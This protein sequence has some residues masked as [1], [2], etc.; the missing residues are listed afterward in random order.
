MRKYRIKYPRFFLFLTIFSSRFFLSLAFSS[1]CSPFLLNAIKKKFIPLTVKCRIHYVSISKLVSTSFCLWS[2]PLPD[3]FFLNRLSSILSFLPFPS[4]CSPFLLN[5]NK[6][7][8]I[9][10]Y[11]GYWTCVT[12]WI[13]Y[14]GEI[15]WNHIINLV[16]EC[17]T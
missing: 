15:E 10:Y 6:R 2:F 16:K 3:F 12:L 7:K 9:W 11:D 4:I 13:L 14:L 8:L 5:T 1:N 17:Y